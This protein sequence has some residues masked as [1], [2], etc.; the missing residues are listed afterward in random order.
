M[1]EDVPHGGD[2]LTRAPP[3]GLQDVGEDQERRDRDV[4]AMS[5]DWQLPTAGMTRFE[6]THSACMRALSSG[7]V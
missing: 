6:A 2:E 7:A 1:L 3:F 5:V 4:A